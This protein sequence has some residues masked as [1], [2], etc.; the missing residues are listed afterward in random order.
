MPEWF[1]DYKV[2]RIEAGESVSLL[3]VVARVE[4]LG[5]LLVA[6]TSKLSLSGALLR[7]EHVC[8]GTARKHAADFS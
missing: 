2:K 4:E 7:L 5:V 1:V 3:L 8:V 6:S